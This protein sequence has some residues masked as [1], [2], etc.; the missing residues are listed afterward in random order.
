MRVLAILTDKKDKTIGAR[1]RM[2]NGRELNIRTEEL[3]KYAGKRLENAIIDSNGFVRAKAGNLRRQVMI[4]TPN[5]V[6]QRDMARAKKLVSKD[7][8]TVYHGTK[9]P[10]LVPMFGKGK[11]NNDYGAGFYTTEDKELGKEW[12]YSG[13]S[14]GE[15]GYLYTYELNIHGLK[16]LDLTQYE[17]VHWIAE[18]LKN[19]ELN[20]DDFTEE[21]EA[22][23]DKFVEVFKLDTAGYDIIIGY[24][25][26]DSYFGIAT[27]FVNNTLSIEKV[28]ETLRYGNLGLQ[29]FL[30]SREA[31]SR[32]KLIGM[33]KVPGKYREYYEKRDREARE[34]FRKMPKTGEARRGKRFIEFVLEIEREGKM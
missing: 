34:K 25:A 19:R 2:D 11:T 22:D 16:I 18:L 32:L 27:R 1:I 15:Q 28:E 7:T 23:I 10:K 29:V 12:A 20:L 14:K 24:R 13:Y 3:K 6:Q 8:M 30:K 33:E 17:A 31:F 21:V 9:N 5:A 26:D 4:Q